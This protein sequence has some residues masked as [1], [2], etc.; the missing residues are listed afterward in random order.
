M[1]RKLTA[2]ILAFLGNQLLG[3]RILYG[4]EFFCPSGDVTCLIAAI[5]EANSTSEED[6]INL[7][8]GTYTLVVGI[9]TGDGATGLPSVTSKYHHQRCW[10]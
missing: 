9:A 8:A 5:N 7:Q 4:A 3:N 2:F 6:I 10:R 1:L